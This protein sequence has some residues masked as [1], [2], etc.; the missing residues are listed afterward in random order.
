MNVKKIITFETSVK[1]AC[2]LCL[3][4]QSYELVEILLEK[5]TISVINFFQNR[6]TKIPG[7][8]IGFAPQFSFDKLAKKF[9]KYSNDYENYAKMT[10]EFM[11]TYDP[12]HWHK[13]FNQIYRLY[14]EK[15][16]R[17]LN[18]LNLSDVLSLKT[19]WDFRELFDLTMDFNNPSMTSD[20]LSE[21]CAKIYFSG[22]SPDGHSIVYEFEDL[23]TKYPVHPIPLETWHFDYSGK[24]FTFFR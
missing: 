3:A 11:E 16:Y 12:D 10:K 8:S 1:L 13:L 2:L 14:Y 19:Q 23:M 18:E 20:N 17:I 9:P 6:I 24:F 15:Y 5:N 7:I 4:Y 21:D 22:E